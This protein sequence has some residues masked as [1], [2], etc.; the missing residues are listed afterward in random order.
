[1]GKSMSETRILVSCPEGWTCIGWQRLEVHLQVIV[2]GIKDPVESIDITEETARRVNYYLN[3]INVSTKEW[4]LEA[5]KE[6][7]KLCGVSEDALQKDV[8][9]QEKDLDELK[10]FASESYLFVVS[11][12]SAGIE[13]ITEVIQEQF[14]GV[15]VYIKD[16]TNEIV[17]EK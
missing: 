9:R 16:G 12:Q 3:G 14:K 2:K 8:A 7:W 11:G 13:T 17:R 10:V 6:Y 4:K 1:M 5:P 15:P